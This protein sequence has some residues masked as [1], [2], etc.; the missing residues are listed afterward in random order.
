MKE[1]DDAVYEVDCQMV[2][3]GNEKI[4]QSCRNRYASF[5]FKQVKPVCNIGML[6]PFDPSD[7]GANP[8]A[9]EAEESLDDTAKKEI[10]VVK[11]FQLKFLGDEAS[12]ARLFG[13]QKDY[14]AQLKSTCLL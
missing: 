2:T 6:M 8:S 10:D 1:I 11:A 13:T 4:G 9:E 7:I 5:L 3:S 14:L 12:G